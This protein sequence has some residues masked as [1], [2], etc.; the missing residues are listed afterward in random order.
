MTEQFPEYPKICLANWTFQRVIAG[1]KKEAFTKTAVVTKKMDMQYLE[2][3][4]LT[5][6]NAI[7]DAYSEDLKRIVINPATGLP[8]VLNIYFSKE[9]SQSNK[10]VEHWKKFINDNKRNFL[11]TKAELIGER[12]EKCPVWTSFFTQWVI[13][14]KK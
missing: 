7:G 10:S 12:P 3:D 4:A 11:N 14:N 9:L 13:Y 8:K 5:I 6:S 1:N 2:R